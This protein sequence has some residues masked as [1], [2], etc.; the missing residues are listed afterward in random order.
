MLCLFILTFIW[1][2]T[3]N[4]KYNNFSDLNYKLETQLFNFI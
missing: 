3:L 4:L 1:K 2:Y